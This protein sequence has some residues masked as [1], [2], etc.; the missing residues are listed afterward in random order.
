ML[1]SIIQFSEKTLERNLDFLK[2]FEIAYESRDKAE[3]DKRTVSKATKG[4]DA[5]QKLDKM[6]V[7][8]NQ[9]HH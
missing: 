1:D 2:E 6:I 9:T 7:S 3:G 5:K 4:A 8:A